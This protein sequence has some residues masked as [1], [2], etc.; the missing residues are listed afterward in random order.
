MAAQAWLERRLQGLTPDHF[1]AAPQNGNDPPPGICLVGCSPEL[2]PPRAFE[3]AWHTFVN[4]AFN[5]TTQQLSA[6]SAML[7]F[8]NPFD[9]EQVRATSEFVSM[10]DAFGVIAPPI[11]WVVH[12]VAP[13]VRPPEYSMD[14]LAD[15]TLHVLELGLDGIIP[16]EREGMVF[17]LQ[18]RLKIQKS[19]FMS[20]T[21]NNIE[22]KRAEAAKI[23]DLKE[24]IHSIVWEYLCLRIAPSIPPCNYK[25]PLNQ[26]TELA[27]MVVGPLIEKG[28]FSSVFL[29]ASPEATE[30]PCQVAKVIDKDKNCNLQ[31]VKR[32]RNMVKVL[33]LLSVESWRHPCLVKL[34]EIYHSRTHI[35]LRMEFCGNVNLFQRLRRRDGPVDSERQYL[36]P[37]KIC[38]IIIQMFSVI[39]HVHDGPGICHRD[40]KPEIFSVIETPEAVSLKLLDLDLALVLGSR[41]M[42]GTV[43]GTIPFVAP[44]VLAG[45]EYDGRAADA[46]SL[47]I[48]LQ[49]ILCHVKV[50]EGT[51]PDICQ[52]SSAP[53]ALLGEEIAARMASPRAVAGVLQ[54]HLR[55]ELCALYEPLLPCLCG[56]LAVDLPSRWRVEQA[57]AHAQAT[58]PGLYDV[59]KATI[60]DL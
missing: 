31:A 43:C 39:A 55:E 47:G 17:V 51:L 5:M 11:F 29:L 52:R 12:T 58:L 7:V 15:R 46:W 20:Q 37:E 27:G 19:E 50:L 44:E 6:A 53:D 32:I 36:S 45:R 4:G 21:L 54:E 8:S 33:Q 2:R 41:V 24:K 48:I 60:G 13:E 57:S 40:L 42:C 30:V 59:A 14:L 35:T 49:E 34:H 26:P 25:L 10:V 9:P 38:S 1:R 18:V 23:S 28:A 56:L 16:E 22:S 3:P